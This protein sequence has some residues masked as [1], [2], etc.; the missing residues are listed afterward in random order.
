M[1]LKYFFQYSLLLLGLGLPSAFAQTPPCS[2]LSSDEALFARATGACRDSA[3]IVDETSKGAAIVEKGS[4]A[5][6]TAAPGT[7]ERDLPRRAA[8]TPV[9]LLNV[10]DVTGISINAAEARLDRFKVER[11]DRFSPA[12]V[13]RV[14]EQVPTASTR[15]A[16]GSA[17]VL[18]VSV[19]PAAAETFELPNVVGRTDAAAGNTLAEFK[20]QRVV[21]PSAAPSGTV[22]AQH[23]D[24]GSAI[25]PGAAVTLHVSDGSL[26]AASTLSE[27]APAPSTT[28]PTANDRRPVATPG[29]IL[30]AATLL[31]LAIGGVLIRRW[32]RA[33]AIEPQVDSADTTFTPTAIAV[34]ADD[35]R[36]AA[37]LD[38]GEVRV[39]LAG[40]AKLQ[41]TSDEYSSAYHA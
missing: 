32:L 41:E 24:S 2:T 13:G 15:V 30:G 3:P 11:R 5:G 18:T 26:A 14:I 8:P 19:D 25:S 38:V 16:A 9:E 27:P 1:R 7:R 22:L 29:L 34:T 40:P 36:F 10:P 21:V 28:A 20:V 12:P 4:R 39:E 17:I 31:A 33:R 35:F 37:H 23:P 6:K